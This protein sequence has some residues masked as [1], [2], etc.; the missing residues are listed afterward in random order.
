LKQAIDIIEELLNKTKNK[1]ASQFGR[2]I[3]LHLRFAQQRFMFES[4]DP[5]K[6]AESSTSALRVLRKV[7]RAII[8]EYKKNERNGE[9]FAL[10]AQTIMDLKDKIVE[11]EYYNKRL[12]AEESSKEEIADYPEQAVENGAYDE[13]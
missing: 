7:L 5:T 6:L 13:E 12:S 4:K 11:I 2:D 3:I 9:I 8:D 1:R 10:L